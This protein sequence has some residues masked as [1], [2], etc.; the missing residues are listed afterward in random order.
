MNI[1]KIY[2]IIDDLMVRCESKGSMNPYGLDGN[3]S[4]S[5]L[6]TRSTPSREQALRGYDM[7]V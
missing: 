1:I 6:D 4:S 7:I 3:M 5:H 2:A